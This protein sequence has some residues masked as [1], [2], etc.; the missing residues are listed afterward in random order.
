MRVLTNKHGFTTMVSREESAVINKIAMQG[1]TPL[2]SLS[3]REQM[4]AEDLYRKNLL[5]RGRLKHDVG[6]K[7]LPTKSV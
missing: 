3:E 2:N 4:L 6:Y 1:F 5:R 7:V